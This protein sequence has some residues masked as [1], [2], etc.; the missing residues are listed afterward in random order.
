MTMAPPARKIGSAA[1]GAAKRIFK[2]GKA[3]GSA[4][5]R[6][7]LRRPAAPSAAPTAAAGVAA[8]AA[9]AYFLDPKSG[10]KRRKKVTRA[11]RPDN[12]DE[13]KQDAKKS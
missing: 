5:T 11:L 10:K 3:W 6:V 2:A 12:G 7:K 13:K 1:V 9:G 8:G 4:A